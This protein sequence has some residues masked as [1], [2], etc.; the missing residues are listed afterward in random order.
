MTN[1][2]LPSTRRW[3]SLCWALLIITGLP[4]I[5]IEAADRSASLKVNVDALRHIP[6]FHKGR[7][8]PF[9]T[10]SNIIMAEVCERPKKRNVTLGL[11]PYLDDKKLA[12]KQF[13]AALELFPNGES[14]KLDSAE[15]VYSWLVEQEK[16]EDVPFLYAPHPLLRK[17][18]DVP[19]KHMKF[20]Y[21]SPRQV[22]ESEGLQKHVQSIQDRKEEARQREEKFIPSLLDQQV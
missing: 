12:D 8:Q 14:R 13:A 22:L 21:V 6:V 19:V 10:F 11:T 1:T 4:G 5:A 17:L 9:D 2:I 3:R 20:K 18:L 7:I 15:L 16:W